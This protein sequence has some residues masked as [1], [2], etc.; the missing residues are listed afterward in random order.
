VD[1]GVEIARVVRV[2]HPAAFLVEEAQN[3]S[4]VAGEGRPDLPP[5]GRPR[6]RCCTTPCPPSRSSRALRQRRPTDLR[7][8]PSWGD[9]IRPAP[10]SGTARWRFQSLRRGPCAARARVGS[11]RTGLAG[12]GG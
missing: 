1:A 11:Q 4:A 2:G 7:V 3:A 8:I 12:A 10:V 9:A 6:T 5:W